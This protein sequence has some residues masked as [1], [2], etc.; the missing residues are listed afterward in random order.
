MINSIHSFLILALKFPLPVSTFFV[1][2][3]R[4]SFSVPG[5]VLLL[6]QFHERGAA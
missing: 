2:S 6:A 3:R 4:K 5:L 1:S